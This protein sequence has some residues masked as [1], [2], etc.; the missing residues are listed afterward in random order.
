MVYLEVLWITQS[1]LG[2]LRGIV[3]RYARSL[4][5]LASLA[6]LFLKG[7]EHLGIIL[8]TCQIAR[9]APKITQDTA[10]IFGCSKDFQGF[11][12]IFNDFEWIPMDFQ[13]FL[14]NV[15]D[16]QRIY[17]IF[18]EIQRI[19]KDV[20]WICIDFQR[21]SKDLHGFSIN[22]LGTLHYFQN[23]HILKM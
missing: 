15:N 22:Y 8:G 3:N 1:M 18:N 7:W 4:A 10:M 2:T 12:M 23:M 20:Q 19:V 6:S 5:S 13:R 17:I 9:D 14:W 16:F 11:S 21:F